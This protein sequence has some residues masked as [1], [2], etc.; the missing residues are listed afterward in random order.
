MKHLKNRINLLLE[1]LKN[2][3]IYFLRDILK[4]LFYLFYNR[5]LI[6]FSPSS[7][8]HKLVG[9]PLNWKLF[10]DFQLK[11]LINQ[12]LKP[13]DKFLEIGCGTLRGGI[14]VIKFLNEGNYF[15][16]DVRKNVIKEARKEVKKNKIKYK[17][18]TLIYISGVNKLSLNIRPNLIWAFLV[19]I[20][21]EDQNLEDTFK[22]VSN[23]LEKDGVFLASVNLGIR[24]KLG[25][26][27]YGFPVQKRPLN[28]Y[29]EIGKKYNLKVKSLGP[30]KNFSEVISF[31]SIKQMLEIRLSEK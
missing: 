31:S 23:N 8:R 19:L 12:G 30:L 22:F 28:F 14:P 4:N 18:P 25:G 17:N 7:R 11:F 27:W 10:R 21:M 26:N 6:Q 20:H 15:G 5:F 1:P 29:K 3:K 13:Q 16:Y 9:N 2:I 24:E